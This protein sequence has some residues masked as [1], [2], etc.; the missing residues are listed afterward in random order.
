MPYIYKIT[1][2]INHKVYIGKTTRTIEERWKEHQKDFNKDTSQK[3]PLYAAMRKYGILAFTIEPIEECLTE[4]LEERERYWIEIYGSFKNG[5]NATLGG[6]GK[7][8]ID[9][10]LVVSTYKET[11]NITKTAEI[12]HIGRDTVSIILDAKKETKL[13]SAEVNQRQSGKPVKQYDLSGNY[14]QTFPSIKSAAISLGILKTPADRGASSHISAVCK[15]KRKTAY[16]YIWRF[17]EE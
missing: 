9:Y 8:Y 5:Y 11:Q 16:G 4:E 2:S 1:N 15:G 13:L 12:L 6:D 14:I 3:R 17:E 7:A 10:D